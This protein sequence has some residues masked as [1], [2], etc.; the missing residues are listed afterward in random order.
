LQKILNNN[1]FVISSTGPGSPGNETTYFGSLTLEAVKKFQCAKGIVCSGD[2]S[3][4]GYG[5]VGPMTRSQ[6]NT[7]IAP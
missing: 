6:L 3:T 5:R 2:S 7:F 1:G 4:T